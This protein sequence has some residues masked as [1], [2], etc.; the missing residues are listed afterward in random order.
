MRVLIFLVYTTYNLAE[1]LVN[2]AQTGD[3]WSCYRNHPDELSQRA[4]PS[5]SQTLSERVSKHP[6]E[7]LATACMS[8][9]YPP[10]NRMSE[11]SSILCFSVNFPSREKLLP[12]R[13]LFTR[14]FCVSVSKTAKTGTG[15]TPSNDRQR[16]TRRATTIP[17]GQIS[18]LNSRMCLAP[19]TPPP[20]GRQL[21]VK[22]LLPAW[23][24]K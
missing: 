2:V 3:K 6:C 7:R 19:K 14:P 20:F 12:I 10:G 13:D 21:W 16:G 18:G 24:G 17:L 9:R 4:A 22:G 5:F 15:E 23:C 11:A 1:Y 8:S